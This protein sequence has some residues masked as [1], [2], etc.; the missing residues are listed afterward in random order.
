MS[1]PVVDRLMEAMISAGIAKIRVDVLSSGGSFT[2]GVPEALTPEGV[3]I[4]E[5]LLPGRVRMAAS[6]AAVATWIDRH[7]ADDAGSWRIEFNAD[8]FRLS[9]PIT[10]GM[11]PSQVEAFRRAA[12]RAVICGL[13]RI[14][15]GGPFLT[16]IISRIGGGLAVLG[17]VD[18]FGNEIRAV[19]TGVAP[20][21]SDACPSLAAGWGGDAMRYERIGEL[22][23][24]QT[25]KP[26]AGLAPFSRAA[27][28]VITCLAASL[29]DPAASRFAGEAETLLSRMIRRGLLV[30]TEGHGGP[31]VSMSAPAG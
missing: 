7:D 13:A 24:C 12:P 29:D 18:V 17:E 9:P 1:D 6:A 25:W 26:D 23:A 28:A 14:R 22:L 21:I 20:I 15:E 16:G 11:P 2:T 8:D 3:V 5:R 19:R 27:H 10:A 4:S 31:R 30:I